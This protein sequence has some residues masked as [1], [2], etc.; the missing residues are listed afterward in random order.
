ME[1]RATE[2][3]TPNVGDVIVRLEDDGD[4]LTTVSCRCPISGISKS[5]DFPASDFDYVRYVHREQNLRVGTLI[6]GG[7]PQELS[8]FREINPSL[9]AQAA[10]DLAER[11]LEENN[12]L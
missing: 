12:L 8:E 3:L 11:F 5:Y 7:N 6:T 10:E 9:F 1:I 4:V 2:G